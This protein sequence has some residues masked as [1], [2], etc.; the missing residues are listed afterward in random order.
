MSPWP[1]PAWGPHQ[2]QLPPAGDGVAL[3]DGGDIGLIATG[4]QH[5]VAGREE[6]G[7]TVAHYKP[8]SRGSPDR[9]LGG[10]FSP[11]G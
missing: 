6:A 2:L 8:V 11:S 3:R 1:T 7:L 4:H 10:H 5:G 9:C